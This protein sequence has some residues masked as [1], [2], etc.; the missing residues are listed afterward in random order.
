MRIRFRIFL[1]FFLLILMC[2][3]CAE[4][5]TYAR[6]DILLNFFRKNE[7]TIA[8]TDSGLGGLSILADIAERSK[9]W[10]SFQKVNFIYFNALFSNQGGYNTLETHQERVS[11][12]DSALNS[13]EMRYNPDLILIGCN[14]LSSIYDDTSFAKRTQTPVKGIIDAGV[15]VAYDALKAHPE[16]KII[17]FATQTTVAQNTHKDQLM[18]KGFLPERILYQACPELA[19][20]IEEDYRGDET[21][22]L[23]FAYVDESLQNISDRSDPLIVSLNCTHY[24][25]SL[26]LWKNAFHSLGVEPVAFL[27]PNAKMNDFLFRLQFQNRFKITDTSV[28]IVS[29]VEITKKKKESLGS[30]LHSLSP[31]TVEALQKYEWEKDLFQW[32][33]FIK[34]Q[35]N[36]PHPKPTR[37]TQ[38]KVYKSDNLD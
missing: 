8:I 26:D 30:L 24:G 20:Y 22:M 10:K 13:L 14:T 38:H 25:Y 2:A 23:I 3:S 34:N 36:P 11:I 5:P 12:F 37:P 17:I 21:D 31:Q 28:R 1:L 16:S 32:K 33:N 7:V 15:N 35:A 9:N 4:N 18:K 6:E 29:M 19:K 27:N